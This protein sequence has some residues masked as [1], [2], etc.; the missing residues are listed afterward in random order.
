MT[1]YQNEVVG[2]DINKGLTLKNSQTG[3]EVYVHEQKLTSQ[4]KPGSV[5]F[6]RVGRV[7]DYYELIGADTFSLD[8]LDRAAKKSLRKMGFKLTPKIAHEIWKSQ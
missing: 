2:V 4:V 7:N 3:E 1:L 8:G 5:F 6:G